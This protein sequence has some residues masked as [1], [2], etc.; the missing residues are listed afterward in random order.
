[1]KNPDLFASISALAPVCDATLAKHSQEGLE[2]YLGEK[3]N[4]DNWSSIK[5]AEKYDGPKIEFLIDQVGKI[6]FS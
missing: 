2:L 5:I 4:W 1:M 6:I 3:Q